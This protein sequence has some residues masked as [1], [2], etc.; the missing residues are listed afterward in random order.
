[1]A[2]ENKALAIYSEVS[3]DVAEYHLRSGDTDAEK[4]AII[5]DLAG[6]SENELIEYLDQIVAELGASNSSEVKKAVCHAV[7]NAGESALPYC[8]DIAYLLDDSDA[9]VKYAAC[10][11]LAVMGPWAASGT[12]VSVQKLLDDQSEVVRCG[13]CAAIGAFGADDCAQKLADM[14]GDKS[15]EVQG[16]ACVALGRLGEAGSGCASEVAAKIGEPRSRLQAIYA[17]GLMGDDGKKHCDKIVECLEDDDDEIRLAAAQQCGQMAAE[18]KDNGGAWGSLT[19]MLG[20]SEGK[21]R[22]A[23]ALALGYMGEPAADQCDAL[24][25]LLEDDFGESG[26]NS[27]TAG[28]CRSR[29]PP[30]TRK[31][32]CAAAAALGLICQAGA[33]VS[34]DDYAS[35]VA[36]LLN[37][38]DWEARMVGCEA[39]AMMGEKAK[40]QATRVSAIFDDERYAVRARAAHACGKLKDADSAAGL[41][42]LIADNC[43]SVREEAMLALAELGDD[44]S[45]Y[46]EKVFEKVN[47]FS[48]TVRAAAIT[49]LGRFGEKGQFYAGAV[50]QKLTGYEAPFVRAAALEAL[51]NMEE[52]GAAFAEVVGE[53]LQDQIPSVR[54]AAVSAIAKMGTEAEAFQDAVRALK[55]DPSPEVKKAADE[56]ADALGL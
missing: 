2:M 3:R 49:A 54:A 20:H 25:E 13:A 56:A 32:K 29:M 31:A 16:A 26:I 12:M 23:A 4:A 38:E 21:V 17:L 51:G 30:S 41:A 37:D 22:C 35:E 18:V 36:N 5:E 7:Q 40:D 15:P 27:L 34:V 9:E 19:G 47:D 44:G 53:Y 10:M 24:K 42:D 14:L 50:A 45:E 8:Q 39:L 46:I 33:D 55:D 11:S 6:R 1:M 48:P 43:P 28:G 52:H